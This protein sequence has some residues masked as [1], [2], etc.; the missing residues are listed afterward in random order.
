MFKSVVLLV[1]LAVLYFFSDL[2]D[3]EQEL[4]MHFVI[5]SSIILH[6]LD[7]IKFINIDEIVLWLIEQRLIVY[8]ILIFQYVW[9]IPALII[10]IEIYI[11]LL[12]DLND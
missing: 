8:C 2:F 5:I 11:E 6:F 9:F 3:V 12:N 4:R 7:V 10:L 1:I